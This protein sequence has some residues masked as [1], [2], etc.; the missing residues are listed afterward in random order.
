MA[1]HDDEFGIK[2][3]EVLGLDPAKTRD[4]VIYNRVNDLVTIDVTMYLQ[5]D[6]GEKLIEYLSHYELTPKPIEK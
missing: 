6:E 4:I 3:C 2:L 5:K 1:V